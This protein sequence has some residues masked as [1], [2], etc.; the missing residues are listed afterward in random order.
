MTNMKEMMKQAQILQAKMAEAQ[1][2][3]ENLRATG[4]AGGGVAKVT[5][6]GKGHVVAVDLDPSLLK[7]DEK[8]ILED[9]IVAAAANAQKKITELANQEMSKVA[10]GMPL[11][12]GMGFPG[13]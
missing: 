1:S 7:A 10:G 3:L 2:N 13:L 6:S 12:G 9:L 5:L 11:P 8:E 4:E